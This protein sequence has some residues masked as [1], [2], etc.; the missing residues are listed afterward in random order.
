MNIEKNFTLTI[1]GIVA[2][3]IS[4]TIIQFLLRKEK[5]KSEIEGKIKISFGIWLASILL[6]ATIIN[7]K[8]ITILN[9]ALDYIYKVNA[10]ELTIEIAKISSI[11]IGISAIWLIIWFFIVKVFAVIFVGKRSD[12]NEMENDNYV[13]FIIK[14]IMLICFLLGL[15]PILEN[16][17]K[18]F[19][20]NI[21][22]PFYH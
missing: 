20:P 17:L 18:A 4:I 3:A 16:L 10:N 22:I 21:E 7:L 19:L 9:E 11:F 8:T 13:Y 14:G 6:G 5:K 2:I 15:L 12:E 1:I